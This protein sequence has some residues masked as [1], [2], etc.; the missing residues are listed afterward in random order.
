MQKLQSLL[1]SIMICLITSGCFGG[2]SQ[3]SQ[4]STSTAPTKVS[5]VSKSSKA[6]IFGDTCAYCNTDNMSLYPFPATTGNGFVIYQN[7][8]PL[9]INPS[10]SG[11]TD[12]TSPYYVGITDVD[13]QVF[14]NN[15]GL[16][17]YSG[18]GYISGYNSVPFARKTT[19]VNSLAGG[20][21]VRILS[22]LVLDTHLSQVSQT[23]SAT[24]TLYLVT[25]SASGY[26]SVV[27]SSDDASQAQSVKTG[28]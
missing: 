5:S 10:E 8:T 26:I 15:S 13:N 17:R 19:S 18:L 12:T 28:I 14:M 22:P 4:S 3:N 1:L 9:A 16:I 25:E 21:Q 6:S 24:N 2:T 11:F 27:S 20:N 7:G 23:I